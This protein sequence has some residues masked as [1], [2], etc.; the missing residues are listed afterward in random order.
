MGVPF[1]VFLET[2]GGGGPYSAAAGRSAAAR[3]K[4]IIDGAGEPGTAV[5][6]F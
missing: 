3:A 1:R 2:L 5:G 4:A 6:A